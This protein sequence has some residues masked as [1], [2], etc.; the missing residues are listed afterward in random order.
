M[1]CFDVS[2]RPYRCGVI[3]G[4]AK[5][6]IGLPLLFVSTIPPVSTDYTVEMQRVSLHNWMAGEWRQY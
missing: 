1:D 4:T 5:K 6:F 2:S 3:D